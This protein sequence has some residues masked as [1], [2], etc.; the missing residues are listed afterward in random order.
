MSQLLALIPLLSGLCGCSAPFVLV[1]E[2]GEPAPQDSEAP[3]RPADSADTGGSEKIPDNDVYELSAAVFALDRVHTVDIQLDSAAY[4]ALGADPY[5]YVEADLAYDGVALDTVGVRIKGRLGSYRTLSQK[6][7]LKVDFNRFTAGQTLSGLEKLNLNNM[8]QDTAFTHEIAA[9]A[10]HNAMQVPAPRVGYAWVTVN[11]ADFGLYSV[12]EAYDDVFLEGR[13][14]D[15]GGN[16]YDGDYYLY[17][18]GS[19]A[20]GDFHPDLLF[21]FELDEGSDVG[22]ADLIAVTEVIWANAGTSRFRSQVGELVDM[23]EAVRLWAVEVWTGHYDGYCYNQNNYRVYFDPQSGLADL[24]PWD[25]DWAFYSTTPVTSPGGYLCAYCK[26]DQLCH[27]QFHQVLD[28]LAL[29]VVEADIDG[30]VTEASALIDPYL[31]LDPRKERTAASI[32]SSQQELH[33][34]IAG[35]SAAL[36]VMGGL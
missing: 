34:W 29:E 12:V 13:Y 27:E 24:F 19:Y 11:G 28:E 26:T 18:S 10:V 3:V 6:A 31:D 20:K 9:Y 2:T 22:Q 4:D 17:D 25:P 5:T 1:P 21:V 7:A 8:V 23:D 36:D 33:T 15:P 35:R 16:L 14:D 32:R 30:L